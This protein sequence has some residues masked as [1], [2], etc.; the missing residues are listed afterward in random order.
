MKFENCGRKEAWLP[1]SISIARRLT[2]LMGG[3]PPD[4]KINGRYDGWHLTTVIPAIYGLDRDGVPDPDEMAPK[5]RK[6]WYDGTST[7]V[8]LEEKAGLVIPAEEVRRGVATLVT[9]MIQEIENL[10]DLFERDCG[11]GPEAIKIAQEAV[12]RVRM[13]AYERVIASRTAPAPR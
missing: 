2:L 13:L 1:S 10:P 5:D 12:D 7:K 11:F 4:G 6:D 8:K 3:I 9:N